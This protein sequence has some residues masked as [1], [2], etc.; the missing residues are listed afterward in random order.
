[1]ENTSKSFLDTEFKD[2]RQQTLDGKRYFKVEDVAQWFGYNE[3]RK[4]TRKIP[5]DK[6]IFLSERTGGGIQQVRYLLEGGLWDAALV[7]EPRKSKYLTDEVKEARQSKIEKLKWWLFHKV[8]P[9]ISHNKAYVAGQE[10]LPEE[11]QKGVAKQLYKL[12]ES[13][14]KTLNKLENLREKLEA[15]RD[16]LHERGMYDEA[17]KIDQAID[18]LDARVD[19]VAGAKVPTLEE[20]V[21]NLTGSL[22]A[23]EI[24]G[25]VCFVAARIAEKLGYD[26]STHMTRN[27]S[28]DELINMSQRGGHKEEDA[29]FAK[30]GRQ[31]LRG[32]AVPTIFIT[33]AGLY[34]AIFNAMPQ[35]SK[36]MAE[37]EKAERIAQL[38][39]IKNKVT[40]VIVPS[41]REFGGYIEGL[42]NLPEAER[43]TYAK[44][45]TSIS[46]I[47]NKNEFEIQE[48]EDVIDE[49]DEKIYQYDR[50]DG[51]SDMGEREDQDELPS[52]NHYDW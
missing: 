18:D 44:A 32:A 51:A 13:L 10:N 8:L 40:D 35:R 37:E 2:V 1:M 15:Q 46:S 39:A 36:T 29:N 45:V 20:L 25:Q 23:I 47:I 41:V 30:D 6:L 26:D 27:L 42:E 14:N 5:E 17:E 9:S 16:A 11:M 43:A 52:D 33:E 50:F 48:I 28:D 4:L 21:T 22:N 7:S 31:D 19:E 12:Y 24:D 49:C 34:R 38:E 3:Q